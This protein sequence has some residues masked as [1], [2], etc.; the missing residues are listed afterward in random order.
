[1]L[2]VIIL[3]LALL[4]KPTITVYLKANPANVTL[5]KIVIVTNTVKSVTPL[6][7]VKSAI[8]TLNSTLYKAECCVEEKITVRGESY[9]TKSLIKKSNLKGTLS[10]LSEKNVTKL[11]LRVK[12][13]LI[14]AFFFV[15]DSDI[16]VKLTINNKKGE[17]L[18]Q[19]KGYVILPAPKKTVENLVK[20][21]V[22]NI[23][24]HLESYGVKVNIAYK[25]SG[26]MLP[27]LSRI[28]L[29]V[30][31]KGN[32]ENVMK[33]AESLGL[34][35][36]LGL[37]NIGNITS[38]GTR[39][40]SGTFT[41]KSTLVKYRGTL[42]TRSTLSASVTGKYYNVTVTDEIKERLKV[43]LSAV[44]VKE[45]TNYLLPTSKVEISAFNSVKD[46]HAKIVIHI[47]GLMFKNTKGFWNAL[48][49]LV[50]SGKV[51]KIV[52]NCNGKEIT[53]N[54]ASACS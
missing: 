30:T 36:Y 24:S 7:T 29:N 12:G 6:G 19:V 26:K 16:A 49:K 18:M 54:W 23:K 27:P 31:I 1:M 14:V 33:L 3:S 15:R 8:T 35:N 43:L 40:I 47:K 22:N 13:S 4:A 45:L 37:N 28:D 2:A 48:E 38:I 17:G 34:K 25:I 53:S 50:E 44:G 9:M 10:V 21:Y 20:V 46:N 41:V 11:N 32:K 52:V 5:N 51:S 39:R 42:A